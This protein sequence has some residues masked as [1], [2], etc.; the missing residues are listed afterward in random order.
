MSKAVPWRGARMEWNDPR[1]KPCRPHEWTTLD[2]G[3]DPEQVSHD[4]LAVCGTCH[5]RRCMST[6]SSGRCTLA[7]HH[8]Q[9][10]YHRYPDL[11]SEPV[12]GRMLD[13]SRAKGKKRP[14][15]A[16]PLQD[17]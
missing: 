14:P 12:S 10:T 7:V 6:N 5:V 17:A 1:E 4:T 15:D 2:V 8:P 9:G 3:P 13:P 16:P 11:M